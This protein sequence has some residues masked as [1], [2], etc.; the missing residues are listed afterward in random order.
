[1]VIERSIDYGKNW[2]VS[3]VFGI[4][5]YNW[6]NILLH[7]GLHLSEFVMTFLRYL[8][9]LWQIIRLVIRFTTPVSWSLTPPQPYQ[10]FAYDC[11]KVFEMR[12]REL[13]E[14]DEYGVKRHPD[15]D[16]IC[17]SKYSMLEPAQGGEVIYKVSVCREHSSLCIIQ[18][19]PTQ[20]ITHLDNIIR[21]NLI[22]FRLPNSSS[23]FLENRYLSIL[24]ASVLGFFNITRRDL[25]LFDQVYY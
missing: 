14:A 8:I 1:M 3:W 10:Y 6:P 25:L 17:T 19:S 16:V 7:L 23:N 18:L 12:E 22:N 24:E 15:E 20:R 21:I 2:M 5:W 11:Q 4:C 13:G 9:P